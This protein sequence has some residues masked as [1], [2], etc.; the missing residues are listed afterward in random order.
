[1]LIKKSPVVFLWLCLAIF[2]TPSFSDDITVTLKPNGV[3]GNLLVSFGLPFPPNHLSDTNRVAVFD[4]ATEIPA[5]VGQLVPWR[6]IF[7]GYVRSAIIQFRL[8][9]STATTTRT[10]T[11]RTNVSRTQTLATKTPVDSTCQSVGCTEGPDV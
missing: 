9:F 1:M 7:R 6:G 11:V 5:Y 2:S 3:S 4:G 8:N 10:V